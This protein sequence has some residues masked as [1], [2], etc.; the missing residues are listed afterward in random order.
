LAE[1]QRLRKRDVEETR[2]LDET[3]GDLSV[4]SRGLARLSFE[5]YSLYSAQG[6]A[7]RAEE[8]LRRAIELDPRNTAFIE[9]MVVLYQARNRLPDALALCHRIAEIDPNNATCQLNIG[10]LSGQL[11]RFDDARRAFTRAIELSPEHHGGYQELARLYLRA[12]V[13]LPQARELAEKAVALEPSANNHF[14]LG[15]AC[16][17]NKDTA[18]ALPAL[19]RAAELEPQNAKYTGAYQS[20]QK[21]MLSK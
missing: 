8:L 17:A 12:Q 10:I 21:R 1:F 4:Y 7:E 13:N 18:G 20:T 11:R 15:L 9:R 2:R 5:A 6:N 19:K 3:I 14:L 16:L